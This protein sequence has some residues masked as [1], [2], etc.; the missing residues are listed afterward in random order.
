MRSRFFAILPCAPLIA[1]LLV[2]GQ[3]SESQAFEANTFF[4]TAANGYGVE[5]CLRVGDEC[6]KAVADAWCAALGHGVAITFGLSDEYS[7]A[8]AGASSSVRGPYFVTCNE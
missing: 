5:D 2:I 4:I 8:G 7:T 3:T 1:L 6:G